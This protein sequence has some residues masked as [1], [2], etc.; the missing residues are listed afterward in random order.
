M[1]RSNSR[2]PS[3]LSSCRLLQRLY[4]RTFLGINVLENAFSECRR[5]DAYFAVWLGC[6]VLL[7]RFGNGLCG[8]S[9]T[10][11]ADRVAESPG[12]CGHRKKIM[13]PRLDIIQRI[14]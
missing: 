6:F 9:K 3:R 12:T 5:N 13:V 4:C 7:P 10:I 11:F 14:R 8:R 2:L 1:G